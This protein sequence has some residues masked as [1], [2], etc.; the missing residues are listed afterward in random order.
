[1]QLRFEN[2]GQTLGLKNTKL[3]ILRARFGGQMTLASA[4]AETNTAPVVNS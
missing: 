3:V 4:V 2:T 1:M